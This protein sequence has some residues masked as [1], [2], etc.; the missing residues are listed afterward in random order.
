[1]LIPGS[2]LKIHDFVRLLHR[3]QKV[4]AGWRALWQ[5]AGRF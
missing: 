1:M 5:G 3:K 4:D 2:L